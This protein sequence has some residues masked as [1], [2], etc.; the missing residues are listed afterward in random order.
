MSAVGSVADA[1]GS[2]TGGAAYSVSRSHTPSDA[3]ANRSGV[4]DSVVGRVGTDPEDSD[5]EADTR[6]VILAEHDPAFTE[7]QNSLK[8]MQVRGCAAAKPCRRRP[9]A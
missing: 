6:D 4:T 8:I 9:T 3:A 7:L 5:D 2:A 1:T